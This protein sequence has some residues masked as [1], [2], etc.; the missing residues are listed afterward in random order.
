MCV[1]YVGNSSFLLSYNSFF[2][3]GGVEI[4]FFAT[5]LLFNL[6]SYGNNRKFTSF[7]FVFSCGYFWTLFSVHSDI[8]T[9]GVDKIIEDNNIKIHSF[10]DADNRFEL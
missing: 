4:V 1:S 2:V 7:S 8:D 9:T 3:F 5:K 6:H 10:E